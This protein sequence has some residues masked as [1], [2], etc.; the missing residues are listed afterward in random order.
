MSAV[1][2]AAE[3]AEAM[4]IATEHLEESP[5]LSGEPVAIAEEGGSALEGHLEGGAAR[6]AETR[7][8][9]YAAAALAIPILASHKAVLDLFPIPK[10]Q[11]ANPQSPVVLTARREGLPDKH[12]CS[13][14]RPT[15]LDLIEVGLGQ[16]TEVGGPPIDTKSQLLLEGRYRGDCPH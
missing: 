8:R 12:L 2:Q 10:L 5:R 3:E 15:T 16:A 13:S 4:S 9:L 14:E 1:V 6:V 7:V 11:R